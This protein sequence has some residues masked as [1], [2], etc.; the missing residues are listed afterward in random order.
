MDWP[1]HENVY[2]NGPEDYDRFYEL[3]S[4]HPPAKPGKGGYI[5]PDLE[6]KPD[7]TPGAKNHKCFYREAWKIGL[8][9]PDFFRPLSKSQDWRLDNSRSYLENK[10]NGK[11]TIIDDE[12][13]PDDDDETYARERED[14]PESSQSNSNSRDA[15]NVDVDPR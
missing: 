8:S 6:A 2:P 11:G 15:P 14:D 7:D 9:P 10:G 4:W 1:Y 3:D 5:Y 13:V 12:L